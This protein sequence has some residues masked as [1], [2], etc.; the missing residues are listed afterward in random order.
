MDH[1]VHGDIDRI[2]PEAPIPI[3]KA[4]RDYYILGGCGNV[5]RNICSANNKCHLISIVGNDNDGLKLKE[6][7]KK[8]KKLTSILLLIQVDVQQEKLDMFVKINKF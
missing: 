7:I 1:Y 4:N 8:V 6:I 5:A 2:S 3:L